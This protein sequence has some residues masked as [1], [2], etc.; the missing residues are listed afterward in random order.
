MQNI[1]KIKGFKRTF[2]HLRVSWQFKNKELW[3]SHSFCLLWNLNY[4][5]QFALQ[6]PV[7]FIK[8]TAKYFIRYPDALN[9]ILLLSVKNL[10]L[11]QKTYTFLHH[12]P[13]KARQK[14]L[15]ECCHHAEWSRNSIQKLHT[16]GK[17]KNK[18][19]SELNIWMKINLIKLWLYH[20]YVSH[21]ADDHRCC[22]KLSQKCVLVNSV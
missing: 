8:I 15:S 22:K 18:F 11:V 13:E 20:Y 5:N 9:K 12:V 3:S 7:E 2:F 1:R 17:L 16:L 14:Y 10:K 6:T 19:K 21:Q 4:H